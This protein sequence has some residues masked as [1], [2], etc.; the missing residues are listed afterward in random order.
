MIHNQIEGMLVVNRDVEPSVRLHNPFKFEQPCVCKISDVREHGTT[1]DQIEISI[2]KRQMRRRR[3]CSKPERRAQMLLTPDDMAR[4][5]VDAP[6][7]TVL[8]D[9]IEPSQ[10]SACST[11][12]V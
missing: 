5:D 2:L 10:H 3:D 9:I 7:L 11:A 4:A 8:R 6:N 12:E 1:I